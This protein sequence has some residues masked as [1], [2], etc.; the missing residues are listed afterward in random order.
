M[1]PI[2][3]GIA[4]T[5][6]KQNAPSNDAVVVPDAPSTKPLNLSGPRGREVAAPSNITPIN[7]AAIRPELFAPTD[8][9]HGRAMRQQLAALSGQSE[10][11]EETR[12]PASGM[13]GIFL[14]RPQLY[15]RGGGF[16]LCGF[17]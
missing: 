2:D 1:N 10:L 5:Q 7:E 8:R 13:V 16:I 9:R 15:A 6:L 3:N 4:D 11:E 17:I 14:V 12:E